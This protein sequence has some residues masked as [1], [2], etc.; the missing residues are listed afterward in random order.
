M[1]DSNVWPPIHFEIL[2]F[3]EPKMSAN[4]RDM[5]LFI[6]NCRPLICWLILTNRKRGIQSGQIDL[7]SSSSWFWKKAGSNK[8]LTLEKC[9]TM[10]K[11][12]L[13]MTLDGLTIFFLFGSTLSSSNPTRIQLP[14]ISFPR[15]G[16]WNQIPS[17]L[18]VKLSRIFDP[19]V[20]YGHFGSHLNR[21]EFA[22]TCN[23]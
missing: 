17:R 5:P 20:H 4:S 16:K 23:F 6:N 13:K 11:Y 19:G 12:D 14:W 8:C 22:C 21:W 7:N 15:A 9:K 3:N 10:V 1:H 2:Y 18:P